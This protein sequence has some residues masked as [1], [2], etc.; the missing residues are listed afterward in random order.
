MKKAKM[1]KKLQL[2]KE[3][4]AQLNNDNLNSIYGGDIVTDTCTTPFTTCNT[5]VLTCYNHGCDITWM[6]THPIDCMPT[7]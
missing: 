1:A 6:C 4:V 7:N 3:T 2:N 5:V